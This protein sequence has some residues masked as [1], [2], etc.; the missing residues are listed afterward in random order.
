MFLLQKWVFTIPS[1]AGRRSAMAN[2]RPRWGCA[3]HML[4]ARVEALPRTSGPLPAVIGPAANIKSSRILQ[5]LI[6]SNPAH[7]CT[8]GFDGVIP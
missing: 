6:F 7:L 5:S 2:P 4:R 1:D 3:L 8:S